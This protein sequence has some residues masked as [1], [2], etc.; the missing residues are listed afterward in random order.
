MPRRAAAHHSWPVLII[1][2]IGVILYRALGE[3]TVGGIV[4]DVTALF[5]GVALVGGVRRLLPVEQLGW[6]LVGGG[7][8]MWV[9]GDLIWN[10]IDRLG[11]EPGFPHATDA[12]YLAGYLLFAAGLFRL[13]RN[14]SAWASTDAMVDA[15]II[16]VGLG[17]PVWVYLVAP[18]ATGPGSLAGRVIGTLYPILDVVLIALLARFL[19]AASSRTPAFRLLAGGLFATLVGDTVFASSEDW[20]PGW[21]STTY[22]M[23][24]FGYVLIAA[25]ANH[26]TMR[27]V[28]GQSSEPLAQASRLRVAVLVLAGATPALVAFAQWA[29]GVRRS[30]LPVVIAWS[31]ISALTMIRNGTLLRR[32]RRQSEIVASLARTDSLTGLPNRRSIDNEIARRLTASAPTHRPLHVAVLD[33]DQFKAYNDRYGHLPGDQLLRDVALAWQEVLGGSFLGR[34]GGEEFVVIIE[35]VSLLEAFCQAESLR[36][37]TPAGQTVS[38]G[39]AEW[40]RRE[41][42]GALL[43]RADQALYTAK[44]NG[45]NQVVVAPRPRLGQRPP[46]E[47]EPL[48]AGC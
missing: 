30:F 19:T 5:A 35:N 12:L 14:R 41:S 20:G 16:A 18:V 37:R 10:M 48:S 28:D 21:G 34:L 45:R 6:W 31:V 36:H 13:G 25:A 17:L 32:L 38:V 22:A 2:T 4:Y 8:G 11:S 33:L 24:L 27:R 47:H 3:H 26:P 9:A 15:L 46:A 29:F 42:A 43:D 23:L 1:G 44:R 40:D 7:L 39:L